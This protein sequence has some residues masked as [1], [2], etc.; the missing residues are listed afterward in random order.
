MVLRD[1]GAFIHSLVH[2]L[3]PYVGL[4]ETNR[5]S[6]VGTDGTITA[7]AL[8]TQ[9]LRMDEPTDRTLV[10]TPND[11]ARNS[12]DVPSMRFYEAVELDGSYTVEVEQ[13]RSAEHNGYV[14]VYARAGAV[15]D[16]EQAMFDDECSTSIS[17]SVCRFN[18]EVNGDLMVL[19]LGNGGYDATAQYALKVSRYELSLP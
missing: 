6:Q 5:W 16:P 15:P 9:P 10:S 18:A 7:T 14:T 12:V 3:T 4:I 17:R 1:S 19:V 13:F 8:P 11:A 2:R